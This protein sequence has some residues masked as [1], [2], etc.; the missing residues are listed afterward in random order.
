LVYVLLTVK[1]S[2]LP[3]MQDLQKLDL[4]D[5]L[6]TSQKMRCL[7]M[8]PLMRPPTTRMLGVTTIESGMNGV[9]VSEKL[10]LPIQNRNEALDQVAS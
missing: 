6:T 7:P 2:W 4:T 10:A 1:S 8:H 9:G 5:I 3:A